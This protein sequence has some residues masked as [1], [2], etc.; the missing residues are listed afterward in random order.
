MPAMEAV[1][2]VRMERVM[3]W[4]LETVDGTVGETVGA[5]AG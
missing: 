3:S 5:A 2:S 4:I 1:T